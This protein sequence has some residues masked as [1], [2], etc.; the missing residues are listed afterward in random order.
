MILLLQVAVILIV[1][2]I[3]R[4]VFVRFHQPAVIGEMVAGLMLGPSL[5]GL[6]LPGSFAALFPAATL[7]NLNAL[8]E[9][10]LI[11]FMFVVG[12]RL[13]SESTQSMRGIVIVTS[14]TSIIVPFVLGAA[15]ATIV[16][17]RLAPPGIDLLPFSFFIGAAMSITAFPVLARI[18]FE[19]NLF[20]TFVGRVSIACAAFND[21]AGW[22]ILAGVVTLVHSENP[23]TLGLRVV[24]LAAYLL[25]MQFAVRPV[26]LRMA[27]RPGRDFGTGAD[28]LTTVLLVML[29]SAIATERLGVHP[30]FGAFYAG[31]MMPRGA[32][33]EQI[34]VEQVL[35]LTQALLLP[36][37]FAFTGLRTQVALIDSWPLWRDALMF[38]GVAI[39]GKAFASAFAARAMGMGWRHAS[40]LGILLN[41]RGL[42]EL[43]ILNV[44]LDL[45]IL[46]PVV[47]SMLV[48]MALV[49]TFMASPLLAWIQPPAARTAVAEVA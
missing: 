48:L 34:C 39:A 7:P 17:A 8:S 45:G 49:T 24:M 43:V 30:L 10:G 44:G 29:L 46:S 32:K 40:M 14:A 31:L 37:F 33:L 18:L 12:L 26:L 13:R 6:L 20:N 1:S 42:I 11:L 15:S 16:H 21:V 23:Q 35:P 9:I 28:D 47:F 36:L 27:A 2:R 38:L 4:A 3:V 5:F 25:V 22:L 41:T 19:R